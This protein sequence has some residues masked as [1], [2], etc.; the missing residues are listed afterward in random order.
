V[1]I[2]LLPPLSQNQNYHNFADSRTLFG[3]SNFADVFSNLAILLAGLTGVGLHLLGRFN[4]RS[5]SESLGYLF[6]FSSFILV[7]VGSVYYHIDPSDSS[8]FSDRLPI[9]MSITALVFTLFADRVTPRIPIQMLAPIVM[10]GMTTVLGW[11]IFG[12][13]RFYLG[14]Q[15]LIPVLVPVLLIFRSPYNRTLDWLHFMGWYAL[16]RVCELYDSQIFDLTGFISGHSL[17]HLTS[18][19]ACALLI[20]MLLKRSAAVSAS[21]PAD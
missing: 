3:I 20:L 1:G 4:I 7:A 10:L 13:L 6:F 8:L 18:G 15:L 2:S 14:I 11:L 19:I 12:D 16:S 21:E 9:T 5:R 17:K